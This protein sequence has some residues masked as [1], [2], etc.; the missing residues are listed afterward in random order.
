M[1]SELYYLSDTSPQHIDTAGQVDR[2]VADYL[3]LSRSVRQVGSLLGGAV[4]GADA[5][6]GGALGTLR[7]M[8]GGR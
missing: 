2:S 4:N 7:S 6:V 1:S 5:V 3:R 8:L